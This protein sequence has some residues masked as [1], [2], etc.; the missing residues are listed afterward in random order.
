MANANSRFVEVSCQLCSCKSKIRLDQYR[1]KNE[2]WTCRSC[3]T[4]GRPNARKGTGVINDPDLARTRNSFYKAQYRCKTGH[5]GYYKDVEF[6][7]KHL[8]ELIDEIGVRPKNTTLDRI[9]NSGHYESGNVRWATID[10][11]VR[12]RKSNIFVEYNGEKMC[13]SDAARISGMDRNA[14]KRRLETGCPPE[15]LFADGKWFSKTQK[16]FPA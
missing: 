12:N 5:G 13:L 2:T 14:L 8:Q 10:E 11:Q 9:N 3:T 16:F 7:F 1:R 6:K 15:F 4:K